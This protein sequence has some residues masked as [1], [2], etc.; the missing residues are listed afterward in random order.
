M[1][2]RVRNSR[3]RRL[4]YRC[5]RIGHEASQPLLWVKSRHFGLCR[6]C[7]LYPRKRT[8]ARCRLQTRGNFSTLGET[9]THC[10]HCLAADRALKHSPFVTRIF[11][12][13]T[14]ERHRCCA[15]PQAHWKNEMVL[16]SLWHAPP[17]PQKNDCRRDKYVP[18]LATVIAQD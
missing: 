18:C 11:F 5:E 3:G 2:W 16:R 14:L 10:R 6:A 17:F 4:A 7:P 12:L 9:L 15:T 8:T 1:L 13:S